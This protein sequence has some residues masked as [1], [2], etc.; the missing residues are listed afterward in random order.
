MKKNLIKMDRIM[1][2]IFWM[3]FVSLFVVNY[4]LA[5][6][7]SFSQWWSKDI[8]SEYTWRYFCPIDLSVLAS[9][10]NEEFWNCQYAIKYDSNKETI[11]FKTIKVWFL[12]NNTWYLIRNGLLYWDHSHDS[13]LS[14][15][16]ICST[17]SF[18]RNSTDSWNTILQLVDK[19]WNDFVAS[20]NPV[21]W[22]NMS[23]D[24]SDTL[25]WVGSLTINYEM[26]P[27]SLDAAKPIISNINSYSFND[28]NSNYTWDKTFTFFVYDKWW[29]NSKW[30]FSWQ[31]TI[32]ENYR[33]APSWLDNQEWVDPSSISVTITSKSNSIVLTSWNWLILEKY[34]WSTY[35]SPYTWD[36]NDRWYYVSFTV[37]WLAVET[38]V[39][40][41][42]SVSDNV[43]KLCATSKHKNSITYSMNQETPPSVTLQTPTAMNAMPNTPI[44]LKVSDDWAWI[45]TG[46]VKITI[47]EISVSGDVV[48]PEHV[49]SWLDLS[50]ELISWTEELW[51]ASSYYVTFQ[52]KEEFP[53]S[54]DVSLSCEVQDLAGVSNTSILSFETRPDCSVY[55][56]IN[57]LDLFYRDYNTSIVRFTWPL[58]VVTW[59]FYPYPVLTWE[60]SDILMCWP[61]SNDKTLTW[62]IKIYSD[63][64]VINGN[65]YSYSWLYVT[66]L[67]F[68]YEDG[69]ITVVD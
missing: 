48:I 45:D 61:D 57:Y 47:P 24:W 60:N 50:F 68:I 4:A 34:T 35:G 9:Y 8:I 46:S 64:S 32:L 53:V 3:I 7:M 59:T 2:K 51:W 19:N 38:P 56:C 13:N 14:T 12:Y 26:C 39:S 15:S 49:Y 40:M 66:W 69:V 11:S 54:T 37:S 31:E 27:C 16:T 29:N 22:L 5:N 33:L 67:E 10:V 44:V 28:S 1:W 58:L 20:P 52:P 63:W 6:T 17:F 42:I 25:T 18:T 36:S 55:G 65:I 21:D 43:W 30:W 23:L 41:E 62:N